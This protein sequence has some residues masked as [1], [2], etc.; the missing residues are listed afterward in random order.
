MWCNTCF[1]LFKSCVLNA[2]I[3]CYVCVCRSD[4]TAV[5]LKEQPATSLAKVVDDVSDSS[6]YYEE[7]SFARPP[8]QT[9]R[10]NLTRNESYCAPG[11]V[12]VGEVH[13]YANS[14]APH[15]EQHYYASVP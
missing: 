1:I 8:P 7:L 13:G 4:P 6:P 11:G 10:C 5:E 3:I 2:A 15:S 12:S 9:K 14:Q